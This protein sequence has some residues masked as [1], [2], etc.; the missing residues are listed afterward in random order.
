MFKDAVLTLK[1]KPQITEAGTVILTIDVQN[2]EADFANK[3]LGIPPINTQAAKTTLMVRDG[4]TTVIGGVF[5]STEQSSQDSTPLLSKIPI[6]GNLFK[7]RNHLAES[8]ELLLFITP[9]ISKGERHGQLGGG[10]GQ[11][12]AEEGHEGEGVI[13]VAALGLLAV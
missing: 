7:N 12:V 9:R 1:V 3:V 8:N 4:A 13:A 11:S 10:C 5:K 6:L 2:N